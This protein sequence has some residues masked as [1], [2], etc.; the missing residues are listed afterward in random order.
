MGKGRKQSSGTAH[1]G[2]L[3]SSFLRKRVIRRGTTR[4]SIRGRGYYTAFR[5]LEGSY[6][7][8]ITAG[9]VYRVV[10]GPYR[11]LRERTGVE[12]AA[13]FALASGMAVED[14]MIAGAKGTAL[15]SPPSELDTGLLR[16]YMHRTELPL[17]GH[18]CPLR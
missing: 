7:A 16:C 15:R 4:L 5:L 13:R 10:H 11:W 1:L 9:T 2:R 6:S 18:L 14:C 8:A 17:P 12:C 3:C